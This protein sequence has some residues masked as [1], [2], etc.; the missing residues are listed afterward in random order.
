MPFAKWWIPFYVYYID[1]SRTPY[2]F[3]HTTKRADPN[4]DV[5][6]ENIDLWK[7]FAAL[8]LEM[9]ITKTGR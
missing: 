7:R 5:K 2:T 1:S 6:L 4:I 3:I 8:D 9:I